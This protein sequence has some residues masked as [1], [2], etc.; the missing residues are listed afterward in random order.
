MSTQTITAGQVRSMDWIEIDGTL[1]QVMVNSGS[2]A[3][4]VE[5]STGT[6]IVRLPRTARVTGRLIPRQP[7]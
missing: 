6:R 3:R 7:Y 2:R 4:I 1:A 5:L